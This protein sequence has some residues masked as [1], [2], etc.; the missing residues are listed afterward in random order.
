MNILEIKYLCNQ[1]PKPY[2]CLVCVCTMDPN[3]LV[4]YLHTKT[5]IIM[6]DH[7]IKEGWIQL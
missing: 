6:R 5:R 4:E 2:L 1:T 7:P 3:K